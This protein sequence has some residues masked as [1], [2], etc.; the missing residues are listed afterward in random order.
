[1]QSATQEASAAI[2]TI[3]S[4]IGRLADISRAIANAVEEQTSATRDI[5][6]GVREAAESTADVASNIGLVSTSAQETGTSSARVLETSHSL[7]LHS[8]KL[9]TAVATFVEKLRAA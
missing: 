1:M 3:T 5:S 6:G 4:T 8:E 9:Q 7:H 2:E